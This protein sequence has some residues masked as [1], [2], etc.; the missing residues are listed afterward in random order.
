MGSGV[1][2]AEQGLVLR[3]QPVPRG[4][5]RSKDSFLRM[6]PPGRNVQE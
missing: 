5:L 6:G 1:A 2:L 4:S 3:L